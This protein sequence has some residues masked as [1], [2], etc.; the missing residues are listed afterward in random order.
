MDATAR[1]RLIVAPLEVAI[2]Q[3]KAGRMDEPTLLFMCAQTM[4]ELDR[5]GI[6]PAHVEGG[7]VAHYLALAADK[8]APVA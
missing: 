1:A 5:A 6:Q 4:A 8:G 2:R 7:P 3:H